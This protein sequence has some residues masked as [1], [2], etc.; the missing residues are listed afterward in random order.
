M[1]PLI[2]KVIG[3]YK[4]LEVIGK[5]GMGTVYKGI[6]MAL[7]RTVALKMID[8]LLANDE[9]FLRR[10][11]TEAKALARLEDPNIVAIYA[12][13]E[14]ELGTFIV[15]EFVD[16][17]TLTDMLLEEGPQRWEKIIPIFEQILSA[18]KH[19]HENNVIHR[20]IKPRNIMINRQG[21]VKVTDFGLAK[22]RKPHGEDTTI[23]RATMGTPYYMSPEQVKGAAVDFRTD[24]YALGMTF[25][26]MLAGRTPFDKNDSEFTIMKAIIEKDFPPPS[27]FN[28]NLPRESSQIIMKAIAKDPSDRYQSV[29]EMKL[30]ITQLKIRSETK[31]EKPPRPIAQKP[32]RMSTAV[33][34]V[35]FG[36]IFVIFLIV[37]IP[38]LFHKD[39]E[40]P[41]FDSSSPQKQVQLDSRF[42]PDYSIAEQDTIEKPPEE[43][44]TTTITSDLT[45][46]RISS[47]P[48]G[49]SV[50]L[51]AI[52]KGTTPT[53]MDDIEEG[54][55]NLKISLDSYKEISRNIDVRKGQTTE[56]VERLIGLGSLAISCE[57][58]DV[59]I[60]IDGVFY[61]TMNIKNLTVGRHQVVIRKTGYSDHRTWVTINHNEETRLHNIVLQPSLGELTILVKP[62]GSIYINDVLRERDINW[63]FTTSLQSGT[64]RVKVTHPSLGFWEKEILVNANTQ[65]IVVDFRKKGKV[66]IAASPEWGYVF[67]DNKNIEKATTAVLELTIGIHV[68]EIKRKDVQGNMVTA[69]EKKRVLIEEGDNGIIKFELR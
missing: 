41:E 67:I 68:I 5:G 59:S 23:T 9:N 26:E 45:I 37:L 8:P 29:S 15:M 7:E 35:V 18:I 22:V 16:G 19:A 27:H 54:R 69:S 6:D 62:Y 3:N 4:I 1:D 20:D 40:E 53:E 42:E 25:Y 13:Q 38:R 12:L 14:S 60:W 55:Y 10:F 32:K 30:A 46:V 56:I 43:D 11:K 48:P 2:G 63:Q 36:I 17:I 57:P 47:D 24:I 58:S 28:P 52:F 64:Y 65:P 21:R 50:Y 49:A 51:N 31:E 44:I 39:T 33:M 66:T 61:R 34:A